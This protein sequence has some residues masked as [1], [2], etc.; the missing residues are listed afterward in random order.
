MSLPKVSIVTVVWND[1]L[2]LEKTIESVVNQTYE[3]VQFIVIDGGST[4]G[5]L[6]VIKKHEEQIDYWVSEKDAGIYDAMNKGILVATGMWVNFMNAG[7]I[8]YNKNVLINIEFKK[9]EDN[10][11]L[12]GKNIMDGRIRIP[13]KPERMKY[14]GTFANHQSIFFNKE[15]IKPEEFFYDLRYKIYGDYE[16]V[17]RLYISYPKYFIL[18]DEIIA[19]FDSGGISQKISYQKRKEKYLALLRAYGFTGLIKGVLHRLKSIG[20]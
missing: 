6:D 10:I 14:G 15:K 1:A 2:G 3:N 19:M 18:V 13:R 9:N 16:L 7:D 11:L 20:L 8:F 17:N 12:Y 4:D 5:T